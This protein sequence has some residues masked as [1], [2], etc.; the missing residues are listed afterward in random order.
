MRLQIFPAVLLA[1][2]S[3]RNRNLLFETVETGWSDFV[4]TDD[5][6]KYRRALTRAFSSGQVTSDG[7][8][9]RITTLGVEAAA[10]RS[11]CKKIKRIEKLEQN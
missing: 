11:N 7:G 4:G 2:K 10:T 3:D 8:K 5:S 1:H 9:T 6:Q